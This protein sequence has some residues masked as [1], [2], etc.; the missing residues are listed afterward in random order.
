MKHIRFLAMTVALAFIGG[1][2]DP[3]PEPAAQG[4]APAVSALTDEK[5]DGLLGSGPIVV[6]N[7]VEL[8]AQRDGVVASVEVETGTPVRKGQLLGMLDSQQI[9]AEAEAAEAKAKSIEADVKN[10]EAETKVA[11]ADASRAQSMWESQLITKQDLEHAHYKVEASRYEVVREKE[12]LRNAQAQARAL[13]FEAQKTKITAPFDGVVA[14][15]YIRAGQ[16]VSKDDKLFWVSATAPMR[17]RFMVPELAASK[18][19]KNAVLEIFS[20]AT[21]EETHM[22]KI[23]AVSPVIDPASGTIEAIAEID[24]AAGTL[25]PGMTAQ[26]RLPKK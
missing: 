18:V 2:S 9:S 7:Q 26:I 12:N 20:L 6:E 3:K 13:A 11:E 14:R 4:P 19:Q 5:D 23:I 15:R 25:R 17:V 21:P 24:G 16:K 1:C 22:A 10:W 8:T